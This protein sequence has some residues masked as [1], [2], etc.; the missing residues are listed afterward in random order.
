MVR[1]E[2]LDG[3]LDR[4]RTGLV[5]QAVVDGDGARF[6]FDDDALHR[7]QFA[8]QR[9]ANLLQEVTV[10]GAVRARFGAV[11]RPGD[12][13][14]VTA[15]VDQVVQTHPLMHV[16]AVAPADDDDR[17][18]LGQDADGPAHGIGKCGHVRA[19]DDGR[20]RAVE[21]EE[22]GEPLSLKAGR[23]FVTVRQ[24]GRQRGFFRAHFDV[25]RFQDTSASG[26]RPAERPAMPRSADVLAC[27]KANMQAVFP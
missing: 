23:Q 2:A 7:R 3:G 15:G 9:L 12:V 24:G 18:A 4:N 21:I 26:R 16:L 14:A 27:K 8:L 10:L 13:E 5:G 17:T 19:V 20:Q 1:K 6:G 11:V 22:H 25:L